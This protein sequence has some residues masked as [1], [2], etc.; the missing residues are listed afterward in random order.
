MNAGTTTPAPVATSPRFDVR[1]AALELQAD[2]GFFAALGPRPVDPDGHAIASF[3]EGSPPARLL[4]DDLPALLAFSG[5]IYPAR[6]NEPTWLGPRAAFL[7]GLPPGTERFRL[8]ASIP[9]ALVR[10]G[11]VGVT[12]RVAGVEGRATVREEGGWAIA[13]GLPPGIDPRALPAAVPVEIAWD[14]GFRPCDLGESPDVR[15]LAAVFLG[16]G[17]TGAAPPPGAASGGTVPAS[18]HVPSLR[19]CCTVCGAAGAFLAEPWRRAAETFPCPGCGAFA[20]WR[21]MARG[22][23]LFLLRR[24]WRARSIAELR[25]SPPG[26]P[27]RILD[28]CASWP[29]PRLLGEVPGIDLVVSEY[30]PRVPPGSELAPG[31]RCEDLER[32]TLPDASVDLVLTS[33]VLEHVRLHRRALAEVHRVL[34]PGG[35]FLFTVP[36]R[37]V[38]DRNRHEIYREVVDPDDPARD[39]DL[40]EPCYHEDTRGGGSLV[41][42]IYD[43]DRLLDELRE[44]GFLA[45]YERRTL[46]GLALPDLALFQAVKPRTPTAGR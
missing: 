39:R 14:R 41:Y 20:R 3:L 46:P 21:M 30:D 1:I 25:E 6:G 22:I 2:A 18:A 15:E 40:R 42:R 19:G 11:P 45:C 8:D 16:C 24:G 34:R 29:V 27:V 17:F 36:F 13:T 38:P 44:E 33:D 10:G 31:V 37:R 35:A 12:L 4:P 23:L 28:T 32:L 9:G 5:G 7:L 26:E 43:V